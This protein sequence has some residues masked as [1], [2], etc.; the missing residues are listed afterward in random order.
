[1]RKASAPDTKPVDNTKRPYW[2][3]SN[4]DDEEVFPREVV[5]QRI[6]PTRDEMFELGW[7]L[8]V[9]ATLGECIPIAAAA[10]NKLEDAIQAK[11]E[12][13]HKDE[14]YSHYSQYEPL[15]ELRV[16]MQDIR[17]E[18]ARLLDNKFIITAY[19]DSVIRKSEAD[20]HLK[21]VQ[22]KHILG[23][24]SDTEL[25]QARAA[26][27]A[28]DQTARDAYREQEAHRRAMELLQGKVDAMEV[29]AGAVMLALVADEYKPVV[30]KLL[31]AVKAIQ[32]ANQ[33][34]E[35]I[36][37]NGIRA[38]PRLHSNIDH[39]APNAFRLPRL[40]IPGLDEFIKAAE[41]YLIEV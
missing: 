40:F 28:A 33:E 5:P 39:R 4:K 7:M 38:L 21:E 11:W 24:A 17:T 6:P 8:N 22:A 32:E 36:Y 35:R 37:R 18:R 29:E 3:Y 15:K 13:D 26:Y 25:K 2:A 30:S 19:Q 1:M 14:A 31:D 9:R 41:K 27:D 12:Y 23:D 16:K 34:A 10:A 20:A